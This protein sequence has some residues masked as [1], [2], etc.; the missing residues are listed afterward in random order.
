[1]AD[2]YD[3]YNNEN[4]GGGFMMGLLTGTVIGAGIGMLLAPKAGSDLRGEL[5]EQAKHIGNKASEQYRRAS[6]TATGWAEKGREAVSQ[7]REAVTRGVDEARG[8]AG[9]NSGSD[10]STGPTPTPGS[11]GDRPSG[12]TDYGRS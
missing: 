5:G 2:S 10:Y 8:Y 4:A 11:F 6:E 9:G 7:A 1:M 12:G 3:R